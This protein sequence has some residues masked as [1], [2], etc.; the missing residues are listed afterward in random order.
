MNIDYSHEPRGRNAALR[1]GLGVM[2]RTPAC[3]WRAFPVLL[4]LLFPCG[5][6]SADSL[7]SAPMAERVAHALPQLAIV[8]PRIEIVRVD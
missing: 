1:N 3:A 6:R 5:A 4:S 7:P 2:K 8:P